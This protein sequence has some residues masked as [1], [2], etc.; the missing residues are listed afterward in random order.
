MLMVLATLAQA[1]M[2]ATLDPAVGGQW[3]LLGSPSPVRS[4]HAILLRNGKVLLSAGSGSD[5][6]AFAAGTFT[7]SVW[8]PATDERT[9]LTLPWDMFCGG[10]VNLPDGRV[11]IA[12]GTIGYNGAGR[13]FYGSPRS[14]VFDPD[15]NT[16]T[17][18]PD[19]ASGRWYPTLVSL[20]NGNVLTASGLNET[21]K[22]TITPELFNFDTQTWSTLPTRN[23]ASYPHL[24]LTASGK[25]LYSGVTTA[26]ASGTPGLWDITTGSFT[27]IPGLSNPT[28][29][30]EGATVLLP[31]AQRQRVMVLGGGYPGITS[32]D[33][34]DLTAPSLRYQ[35]GPPLAVGKAYVS[36]VILPD[37][38]VFEGG[39]GIDRP[40]PVFEAS[41][42]D[43]DTNAFTPM[44][45]QS[46][47]RTYHSEALLLPDGRVAMVGGN[48]TRTSFE[49]RM[50][51][52]SPPYLFRGQR[53]AITDAPS[54][55]TYGGSYTLGVTPGDA[56]LQW[57]SLVRPSAVT[58][59][60]DPDQRLVD[61]ALVTSSTGGTI[62][63]PTN[64]NLAPPGWYLLFV[65]DTRGRPSV[66]RW[67]H[68]TTAPTP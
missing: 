52:F 34:L 18:L 42:Y 30:R 39:G 60:T 10:H 54:E 29:R 22:R 1:A 53:P 47:G 9:P 12:G 25:V 26:P 38:T 6:N 21:G 5:R 57:A 45:T 8:D 28:K 64:P 19:M 67:V 2:A 50:E 63:V 7:A 44:N 40:R 24:V 66:G 49:M 68:L 59:S 16:F 36:A 31:P 41:I 43:P 17:R 4:V 23:L 35:A 11:L 13:P 62:T 27:S 61:V 37:R 3:E 51:I 15:T 48:P 65:S 55:I 46:V 32:T 14:Y 33:L 56:P 58:H 20:G